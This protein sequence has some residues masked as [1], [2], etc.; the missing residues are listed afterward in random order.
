MQSMRTFL[1][2]TSL[3]FLVFCVL[4]PEVHAYLDPGSGSMMLQLLLAGLTGIGVA[5]RVYWRRIRALFGSSPDEGR[6][7]K[8]PSA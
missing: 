2:R 6:H 1:C 5:L 4:A 8:K 7:K 3:I